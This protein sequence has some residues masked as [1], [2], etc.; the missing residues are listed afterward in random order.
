MNRKGL[1]FVEVVVST[2]VLVLI[3]AAF[4][5][6]AILAKNTITLAHHKI[7]A[8]YWAQARI[9]AQRADIMPP[10]V[11]YDD[12]SEMRFLQTE[13]SAVRDENTTA[14]FN[15]DALLRQ[16]AIQVRWTE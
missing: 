6:L 8:M 9:E 13:K 1:S 2:L 14:N 16:V 11:A 12:P 15:A 4:F 10:R 7:I 3:M 5:G